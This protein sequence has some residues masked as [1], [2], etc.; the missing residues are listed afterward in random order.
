[1][2]VLF[3]IQ[4]SGREVFRRHLGDVLEQLEMAGYETSCH[5][6]TGEGDAT[7]A[8]KIAVERGFDLLFAQVAME[9]L[10]KS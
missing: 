6:T 8:A 4:Q 1:M 5:A 2:P 3:I 10:T 7:E 9:H